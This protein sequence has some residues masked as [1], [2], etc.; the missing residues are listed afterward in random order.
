MVISYILQEIIY[1]KRI[2]SNNAEKDNGRIN[3]VEKTIYAAL[4]NP[5]FLNR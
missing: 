5:F 1:E 3:D 4:L 2:N